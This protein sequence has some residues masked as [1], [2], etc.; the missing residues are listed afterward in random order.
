MTLIIYIR[1]RNILRNILIANEIYESA[2]KF[3]L[4]GHGEIFVM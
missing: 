3:V 1:K 2:I 4:A